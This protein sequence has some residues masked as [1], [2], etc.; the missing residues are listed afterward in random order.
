MKS[1]TLRLRVGSNPQKLDQSYSNILNNERESI[2]PQMNMSSQI[3]LANIGSPSMMISKEDT[4]MASIESYDETRSIQS[5]KF[6][7]G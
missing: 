7:M 5:F 2:E 1:D 4:L 6:A 3:P